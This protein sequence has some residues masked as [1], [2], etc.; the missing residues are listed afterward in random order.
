MSKT[1]SLPTMVLPGTIPIVVRGILA[2][3]RL[4]L[5]LE[6][7]L[8]AYI[9]MFVAAPPAMAAPPN[10]L[11]ALDRADSAGYLISNYNIEYL[12]DLVNTKVAIQGLLAFFI[13]LTWDMYRYG[14]GIVALL[15]DLTL[16]FAWLDYLIYPIEETAKVID[17]V[18]DQIP[19]V[20]MLLI[21]L[22]IGVGILRM[23]IGQKARGLTDMIGSLTAWG[24]S[25]AILVNPVTWLTGPDGILTRTKEGAQQLSAQLVNP[26]AA[27]G[28]VSTDNAA[29][30]LAEQIVTIFVRKPHQ[31][32]AYGG[33]VD[34]GGCEQTYNENLTKSGEDLANAMLK[35][36]PDFGV[37]IKEP[38]TTLLVAACILMLGAAV[39]LA[40]TALLCGIILYEAVDLLF[41]ALL[42]TWELFRSVG[43][44]G[45]YRTLL[46]IGIN[47]LGSIIGML[48]VIV[49][50]AL[51]L[52]LVQYAFTKWDDE[53]IKL[54]ILIDVILVVVIAL[55]I[56][57]RAKIRKA[58]EQMKERSKARAG[59]TPQP[60]ALSRTGM[61]R[62]SI[63]TG[64]STAASS[65]LGHVASAKGAQLARGARN[66][67]A[68][69]GRLATAP[70]RAGT[71]RLTRPGLMQARLNRGML[72]RVGVHNQAA[73]RAVHNATYSAA[74]RKW[75]KKDAARAHKREQ[76]AARRED[77]QHW[78]WGGAQ[79]SA[80]ARAAEQVPTKG[81]MP[82]RRGAGRPLPAPERAPRGRRGAVD[83]SRAPESGPRPSTG[84]TTGRNPEPRGRTAS[85]P[86]PVPTGGA[87]TAQ[88]RLH[89]KM[90]ARRT[91]SNPGHSGSRTVR[92]RSRKRRS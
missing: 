18:L 12:I 1:L 77:A 41:Q 11:S 65:K 40:L 21:T 7:A 55:V 34:G 92:G 39:L 37:A 73:H 53:M 30:S 75:R 87:G 70:A 25:S 4:V 6:I 15:I 57:Q 33:L 84:R 78:T 68:R 27:I 61:A 26:D 9:A 44:G 43:P 81:R 32:V 67:G 14:V 49:V 10:P 79:R 86:V 60:H 71:R 63:L 90:R 17:A 74:E 45:S 48:F 2:R 58:L 5:W 16:G 29:G 23:W 13:T 52:A 19:G 76:R 20:R 47:M 54:F 3:P 91:A 42:A 72:H 80:D 22:A 66:L 83:H 82:R 8:V 59:H 38:T 88:E 36:S 64:V 56:K 31:F 51:Y 69:S 28:A 50:N 46:G 35:C 89:A 85:D 62:S 24:I